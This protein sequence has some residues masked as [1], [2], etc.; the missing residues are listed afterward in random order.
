MNTVNSVQEALALCRKS[1]ISAAIFSFAINALSLTP[2]FYM[3]NVFDKAVANSSFPTLFSLMVLALFLYAMFALFEWLRSLVMV[4]IADRLD[5]ALAP[6]LYDLCFK[7]ESGAISARG[8]GSQPLSDLNA[9]RQFLGSPAATAFFDLP[10]IPVFFFLMIL[11]HPTLA[12]VAAIC[13]LI[14][15]FVAIGNQ[16]GTTAGLLEANKRSRSI[17]TT[18]EKNLRNAEVAAAM[19]MMTALTQRWRASQDNMLAVQRGASSVASGYSAVLKTLTMVMQSAAITTGA[20]LVIQQEISPGVMIVAALLL[21]KCLQPIQQAVASWRAFVEAREQYRRLND[22]LKTFPEEEQRMRLPDLRGHVVCRKAV[23][24]PPGSEKP[25][26]ADIDLDFLPGTVTVILG[27][28]GAGKSTLIRAILGLWPTAQG[29]VRIDGGEAKSYDRDVIGSQ[30]GYLPQEIELFEG[31]VAE[32]IA[33]FGEIDSDLVYQ[34]AKDAGIVDL[35]LA[36]PRGF[37][38]PI[39]GRGAGILSPGQRQRVALARAIYGKPQLIILDEPNSNLDDAGE[40][41]LADCINMLKGS[42]STVIIV[43]HRPHVLPLADYIVAIA[44]GR[45]AAS[46]PRDAIV[47]KLNGEAAPQPVRAATVTDS[48]MASQG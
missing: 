7:G 35:V 13:L 22:I 1:I 29:E 9:F 24:V 23:V 47:A 28:S 15:T 16:R 36:L 19:G 32:N 34:A 44:N 21:G 26:L 11:F 5:Y 20:V 10:W 42:G 39:V 33:R 17:T 38:T 43:S 2:L 27:A 18:T 40:R 31:T 14:M 46:G 37:D 12:A 3:L 6:R 41:A 4:H 8:V 48:M 45:V 30:I 25:T